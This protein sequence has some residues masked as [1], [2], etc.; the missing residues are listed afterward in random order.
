MKKHLDYIM[1]TAENPHY[2]TLAKELQ[3]FV[4]SDPYK[5]YQMNPTYSI[6]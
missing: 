5:P 3:D 6:R 4:E 1:E 2:K